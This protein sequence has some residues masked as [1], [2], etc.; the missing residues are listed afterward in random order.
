MSFVDTSYNAKWCPGGMGCQM[1]CANKTGEAVTVQCSCGTRFCYGCL[2]APHPPI[3]CDLLE[4]W[5]EN[6]DD[7]TKDADAELTAAWI[8]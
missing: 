7:E 1:V 5:L 3:S 6:A 2:K 4:K 8:N